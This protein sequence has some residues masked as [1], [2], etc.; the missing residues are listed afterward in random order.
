MKLLTNVNLI[1]RRKES[2][3]VLTFV[4]DTLVGNLTNK[5]SELLIIILLENY[6]YYSAY[7]IYKCI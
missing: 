6:N 1:P 2:F 7:Q 5:S 3:V 4:P